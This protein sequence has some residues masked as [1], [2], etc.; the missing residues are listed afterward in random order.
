MQHKLTCTH[1]SCAARSLGGGEGCLT[2]YRVRSLETDD[3]AI[4]A[5]KLQ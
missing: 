3:G 2:R 1:L 5:I 4:W